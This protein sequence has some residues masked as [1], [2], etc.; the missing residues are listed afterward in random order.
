MQVRKRKR[1][2]S[3]TET[4]ISFV[5]LSA[6]VVSLGRFSLYVNR[7]VDDRHLSLS[8]QWELENARETIGSWA[9]GEIT[10]ARIEQLEF[11]PE[12]TGRLEQLRWKAT[13]KQEVVSR[14]PAKDPLEASESTVDALTATSVELQLQAVHR[15]QPIRP[16]ELVFWVL[17]ERAS[18]DSKSAPP[19]DSGT[20]P[21]SDGDSLV[22]P[23][24][25]LSEVAR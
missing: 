19:Q 2:F 25:E 20:K 15:G 9:A 13:V 8:L 17:P 10:S 18:E 3:I 5:L 23:S 14:L 12:L 22:P 21:A 1:G 6:I 24:P 11:S 7:G 4:V 16:V